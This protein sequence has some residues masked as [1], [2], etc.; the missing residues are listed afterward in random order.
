MTITTNILV[1]VANDELS[2]ML[3][4]FF[5]G[6][7]YKTTM[8][9]RDDSIVELVEDTVPDIITM[10]DDPTGNDGHDLYRRIRLSKHGHQV[11]I[12]WIIEEHDPEGH[13]LRQERE[14]VEYIR[15]PIALDE[16]ESL[17]EKWLG[18]KELRS[19]S[20]PATGLPGW[21]IV[22]EKLEEM[23]EEESWGVVIAGIGGLGKFRE[24]Y[25]ELASNDVSQACSLIIRN[26][27]K[28]SG[29]EDAFMGHV[30]PAEFAIITSPES[31]DNLS[32]ECQQRLETSIRYFYPDYEDENIDLKLTENRLT[33]RVTSLSSADSEFS[34]AEEFRSALFAY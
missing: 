26:A 17:A 15:R 7:G 23:Q 20:N 5:Q 21:S 6:K 33:A 27:L 18:R 22:D 10:D 2:E 8:N 16:L 9:P 13:L 12:L 32:A 25:G 34:S 29:L 19:A 14:Y 11:P 28:A 30:G 3:R 4:V 31:I 24:R 1:A